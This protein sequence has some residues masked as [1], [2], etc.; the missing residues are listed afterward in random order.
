[1]CF[2]TISLDW[3]PHAMLKAGIEQLFNQLLRPK[4]RTFIPDI[5][6]DM[7]YILD[8]DTYAAAELQDVVRKRFVKSWESL[9]EGYKVRSSSL[10]ARDNTNVSSR[11]SS[12]RTTFDFSSDWSLMCW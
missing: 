5:Y 6:K 12:L 11:T 7:T 10:G 8:D 2:V 9:I 4:L 1:M 3:C